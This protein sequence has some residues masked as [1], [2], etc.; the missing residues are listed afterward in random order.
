MSRSKMLLTGMVWALGCLPAL[1][2]PPVAPELDSHSI[3]LP[4]AIVVVGLVL[5]TRQSRTPR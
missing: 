5:L 2:G 4:V 1:A 3:S